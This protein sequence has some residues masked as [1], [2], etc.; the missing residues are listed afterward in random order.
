MQKIV[1][2]LGV[3]RYLQKKD[4]NKYWKGIQSC[5]IY[6][7]LQPSLIKT[8]ESIAFIVLDV[9]FNSF[10]P[11]IPLILVSYNLFC[12]KKPFQ[13]RVWK[14]FQHTAGEHFLTPHFF[15]F[16]LFV[17]VINTSLPSLLSKP[18]QITCSQDK[19]FFQTSC[20]VCKG[21]LCRKIS[22][23]SILLLT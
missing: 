5:C 13:H 4:R 12:H 17:Q 2:A 15:L 16:M 8:T 10:C 1:L 9:S 20:A 6:M 11:L 18:Q 22:V 7:E 19:T 3:L 23:L 14:P 21:T